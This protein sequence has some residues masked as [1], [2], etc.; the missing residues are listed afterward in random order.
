VKTLGIC[1]V[2]TL[3]VV[4]ALPMTAGAQF[5]HPLKGQWSGQWGPE[6]QPNRLLL[7]LHW[8][9]KAITGTINPGGESAT[10]QSVVFDYSDPT[11]WKITL[12][13]EG[14]DPAGKPLSIRADGVL[15]NIGAYAKVFRGT[16]TEGGQK[17]PFLVT[18]N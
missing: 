1:A 3:A 5:G 8:D 6:G 13:A 18:R 17:G 9:G 12:E 4:L 16:W 11:A 10:V 15:E 2:V 14:K 7:D